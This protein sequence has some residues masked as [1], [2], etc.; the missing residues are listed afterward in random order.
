MATTEDVAMQLAS[1]CFWKCQM[2]WEITKRYFIK[3]IAKLLGW[4]SKWANEVFKW[5]WPHDHDDKFH[6]NLIED[7]E[8][9]NHESGLLSHLTHAD[10]K[11]NKETNQTC[12]RR[13]QMHH[14]FEYKIREMGTWEGVGRSTV[15]SEMK[16]SIFTAWEK[17]IWFVH[18][19]VVLWMHYCKYCFHCKPCKQHQL[20]DGNDNLCA[21]HKSLSL[22]RQNNSDC[23]FFF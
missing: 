11:C 22:K 21:I 12:G 20:I 6:H 15:F 19:F 5:Y 23:F 1:H 17:N 14:N 10:A 7:V 18:M 8:E 16:A 3:G 2:I 4:L 13:W 9:L